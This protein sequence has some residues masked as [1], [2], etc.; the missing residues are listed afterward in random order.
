MK[1]LL[2]TL[3]AAFSLSV[4][5]QPI[6]LA[7]IRVA[8]QNSAIQAATK[9]A[10]WAN[11]PMLGMMMA[12]QL[13]KTDFYKSNG[14]APGKPVC[15][16]LVIEADDKTKKPQ[17]ALEEIDVEPCKNSACSCRT[18]PLDGLLEFSCDAKGLTRFTSILEKARDEKG[19]P[20][21]TADD[22]K[23]LKSLSSVR[24]LVRVSAN[25][26]DITGEIV[27]L[28][29]THLTKMGTQTLSANPLAFAPATALSASA[30]AAESGMGNPIAVCDAVFAVFKKNGIKLDFLKLARSTGRLSMTL[31]PTALIAYMKAEGKSAFDKL[32]PET[33]VG[34]VR[35]AATMT[36]TDNPATDVSFGFSDYTPG[37]TVAQRFA[38]TLPEAKGKP[39]YTALVGSLYSL[40]KAVLPHAMRSL[41]PEVASEIK[42]MLV[43]LPKES[44]GAIAAMCWRE[45]ETMKFLIRLSKDEVHGIGSSVNVVMGLMMAGAFCEADDALDTDLDEEDFDG[46][47]D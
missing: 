42:P 14:A 6:E 38:A 10:E 23:D 34:E 46:D 17:E 40:M 47:D 36:T 29:G 13:S 7:Q 45:K 8:D 12:A 19:Q 44:A 24:V 25:G 26:L 31:D 41:E 27:P 9:V 3:T 39:I 2:L 21:I 15:L 5:A 28:E 37:S 30:Y 22:A 1:K 33:F 20:Y 18:R 11:N 43:T 4:F 16:K 32:D 35:T